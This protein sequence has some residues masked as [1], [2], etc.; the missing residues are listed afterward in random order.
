MGRED[1]PEKD[2]LPNPVFLDFPGG[3]AG[4]VGLQSRR[5]GF[6]HWVGMIPWRRA[7]QLTLLFLPGESSW[8][9]E[10]GGL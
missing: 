2:C 6:N 8:T 3:S 5:P 7:Q 4:R 10:P 1:P 9:E